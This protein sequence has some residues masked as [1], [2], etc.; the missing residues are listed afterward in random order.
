MQAADLGFG[1]R[2]SPWS[3][4]AAAAES[5]PIGR[6]LFRPL[7]KLMFT[8]LNHQVHCYVDLQERH[9]NIDPQLHHMALWTCPLTVCMS[10]MIALFHCRSTVDRAER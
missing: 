9:P 2:Q 8:V 3:F 1:A 5:F 7:F 6:I 10:L 4:L